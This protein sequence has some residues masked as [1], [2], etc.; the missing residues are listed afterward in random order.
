M[1]DTFSPAPNRRQFI[2]SAAVAAAAIAGTA[3]AVVP[4][5]HRAESRSSAAPLGEWK[6]EKLPIYLSVKGGMVGIPGSM[7]EKFEAL[8]AI[9]YDGIELNS[10]GG[11][12]KAEALAASRQVGLPIHGVVDS[13]HWNIRLSDPNPEVRQRGLDGLLTAIKDTHF[14][15][16]TAVLL[17][18]GAVRDPA[19]ENQQQVWDRSIEQIRKAIPLAAKLGIHILIENVWN[20]FCYK[21][22][23]PDNQSADQLAAYIDAI[24]SPWVGVYFDIGNHQKYGKPAQWIRTLGRRI[25]KLDVK[26]WGKSMDWADIGHGD[27]DWPD[28]RKA[29]REIGFAGWAT[30]E[31]GGGDYDRLK[32]IHE[33]MVKVFDL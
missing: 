22:D 4:G 11:E 20:G 3:P 16:G 9:G 33:Q 5:G 18:P 29:L 14:V 21:H 10:P 8:K 23:G 12:N 7:V 25:V 32:L 28:V 19:N 13:I 6:S 30:A 1:S 24:N 15:G 26:D 2:R 17:V 27:V 31:V